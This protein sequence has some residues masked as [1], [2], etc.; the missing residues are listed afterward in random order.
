M[1]V[2]VLVL[3]NSIIVQKEGERDEKNAKWTILLT[4]S[5]VVVVR[6]TMVGV[7]VFGTKDFAACRSILYIRA[8]LNFKNTSVLRNGSRI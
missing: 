6:I 7:C 5:A 1:C 8:F 4:L 2:G 3:L